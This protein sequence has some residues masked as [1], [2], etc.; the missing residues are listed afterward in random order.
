VALLPA[1]F[2]SDVGLVQSSRVTTASEN[3]VIS[4][5]W[6]RRVRP[7]GTIGAGVASVHIFDVADVFATSTMLL[8]LSGGAGVDVHLRSRFGLRADVR[9]VHTGFDEPPPSTPSLGER[10]L[11]TWRISGGLVVSGSGRK[12]GH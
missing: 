4:P 9:Y 7:Y 8:A 12:S 3:V 11:Q 1:F 5:W 6:T 2:E 10:F